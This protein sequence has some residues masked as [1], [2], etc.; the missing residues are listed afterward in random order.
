[1][2]K[3][4][5]N[6]KLG[7]LLLAG[8]LAVGGFFY[9]AFM[10]PVVYTATGKV[11]K[12][13]N[14]NSVAST[15]STSSGQATATP[16][17][18]HLATPKPV[19]AIYMTACV[20]S[21]PSLRSRLVK[22]ANTT[23]INAIMINIKDETGGVSF[24]TG[25][26]L[27]KSATSIGCSV[28]D[29]KQF[30]EELHRNNIYAIGRI[31]VFQD[32]HFVKLH[33][34]YA[35]KRASDGAVWRDRK[36]ISWLDVKAK[37]VWDYTAALAKETYDLGFDEINFDY[38]R[39]PSDGNMN[40][41][42]YPYYRRAE[43]TKAE[44]LKSFFVYLHSQMTSAGIPTSVDLFGM[45]ATNKDDLG[46]GQVLENALPYFDYVAP[47]VYPSHW[48]AGW[49]G[50]KK[51]ATV[52]YEVIKISMGAAVNKA[53]MASSSPAKLRPWLQDFDLGADYTAPMIRA[54]IK[55]TYDVG[56]DS[57]MIWDPK[58]VYTAGA[59]VQQ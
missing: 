2:E 21:M 34:E 59:Y 44:A 58:N 55:A 49:N 17:V 18:R 11:A 13:A 57:W 28:P 38:I 9:F 20:A 25:N 8:A 15:T 53:R 46:I 23:E 51:P 19:K 52:P 37:P 48:P 4:R 40:D 26:P 10:M 47:M 27:F 29:L 24:K 32:P 33:P 16:A 6:R 31:A 1:M 3:K 36:G 30:V 14:K 22:L 12:V 41:I 56:L 50:F 45:T 5:V 39:F 35:V 54:Q 7:F 43:Q 42:A